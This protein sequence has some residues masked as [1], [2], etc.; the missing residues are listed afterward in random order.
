MGSVS[1]KV[2]DKN[3]E[4][5][6]FEIFWKSLSGLKSPTAVEKFLRSFISDVEHTM[7]AKRLGVALM[8]AKGYSYE[9]IE[10]TLK[11][12]SG[13]ILSVSIRHKIG[14][15]GLAPA[16]GRILRD[17]KIQGFMDNIDE[18]LLML[19]RPGKYGSYRHQKRVEA[20]RRIYKSRKKRSAL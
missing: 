19:S 11:V 8:L 1:K 2:L 16:L 3:I 20:G 9:E 4:E 5:R 15:G 14:Q 6:M 17:E 7:L 18:W 13:T 12:S 10:N